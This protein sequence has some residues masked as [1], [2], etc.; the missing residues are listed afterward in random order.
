MVD[1]RK[2]FGDV[3]SSDGDYSDCG[4]D[5]VYDGDDGD[6]GVDGADGVDG[7]GGGREEG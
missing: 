3:V 2:C 7:S 4:I 1:D 5:D 6:D